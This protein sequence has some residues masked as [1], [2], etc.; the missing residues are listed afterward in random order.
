MPSIRDA[1]VGDIPAAARTLAVAFQ[2]YPWTCWS[3]PSDDYAGR[4][5]ELQRIYLCHALECGV[6][7]VDEDRRGVAAF[8]PPEAPEPS[9]GDRSRIADLLGERRRAL[10]SANLPPRPPASWDLA[11]IGVQPDSWGRGVATAILG[12]GLHRIDGTGGAV[13]LETSDPRNVAWYSRHGF[14]VTATT[15]IPDGPVV[16]SMLRHPARGSA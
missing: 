1:T 9:A 7:L 4:L 10:M 14:R 12:E 13:S 6:V 16:H 3:I 2:D 8:L 11:T 5:E 15:H